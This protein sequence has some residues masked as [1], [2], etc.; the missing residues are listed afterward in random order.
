MENMKDKCSR[1]EIIQ[2]HQEEQGTNFPG[3][4]CNTDMKGQGLRGNLSSVPPPSLK[5]RKGKP[6]QIFDN[7][8][9]LLL[10]ELQ[11]C[12]PFVLSC[13]QTHRIYLQNLWYYRKVKS[14]VSVESWWWL[15]TSALES[16]LIPC[17]KRDH[18]LATNL[19]QVT[20]FPVKERLHCICLF[21]G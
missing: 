21:W 5:L 2:I 14:L 20:R 10:G 15:K 6:G 13:L 19:H 11:W 17:N 18:N 7:K 12:S 9:T 1:H 16:K 3:I 4:K 8:P